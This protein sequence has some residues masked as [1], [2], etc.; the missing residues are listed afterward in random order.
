MPFRVFCV[1]P[2]LCALVTAMLTLRLL[3]TCFLRRVE[4]GTGRFPSLVR[5]R[6]P[7]AEIFEPCAA[8][9]GFEDERGFIL[10]EI[11]ALRE[12]DFRA[13]ERGDHFIAGELDEEHMP[14]VWRG[15]R[16]IGIEVY[17]F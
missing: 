2:R 3:G 8:T 5:Q 13:I 9:G 11:V 7:G 17:A 15:R 12:E 6:F 4:V 16:F 1:V 14:D 10:C